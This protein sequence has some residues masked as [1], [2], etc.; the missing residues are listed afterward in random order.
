VLVTVIL[1]VLGGGAY[2]AVQALAGRPASADSGREP[3]VK[4]TPSAT[5][6]RTRPPAPLPI[7]QLRDYQVHELPVF[8][9]TEPAS[10]QHRR[11]LLHVTVHL[12]VLSG[13]QP[14]GR[15]AG[16]IFP[17]VVFAPGF[18]QCGGAYRDLLHQWASAGY[19]VAA[20]DF[21]RT[22]CHTV[23]P[24][25][26]DLSNQP[27]DMAYVI[28]RLLALSGQP[29]GPL[30]GMISDTKIAVA[31]H[32]DGGDTVAAMAAASCCEDHKIRAAIV[33]AGARSPWLG[34][35]WFA[36]PTPP[37][38][39]VQGTGDTCNPPSA[40]A[41]LYTADETGTRYYLQ[42]LGAN[43]L[44]PYEGHGAPELIVARV[45]LAFLD[46]YVAGQQGSIAA[47]RQAGRVWGAAELLTG[48]E[49]PQAD[50]PPAHC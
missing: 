30:R 20:V 49:M 33:L 3:S 17:L 23:K 7:G 2:L 37:M 36:G 21:P 14:A 47:M 5:P 38:L 39:F 45:T 34:G 48:G 41:Q 31:G 4:P 44:T 46:R 11:R 16:G 6:S 43:H 13:A 40:S 35:S 32:S 8:S 19:V 15:P 42:L 12:P 22:N 18:L 50:T 29:R 9:F 24:F 1:A 27:A 26:P 28:R 25:E 10:A